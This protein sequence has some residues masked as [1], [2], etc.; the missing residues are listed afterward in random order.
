[1][2]RYIVR[3]GS[4][5]PIPLLLL[6]TGL[7]LLPLVVAPTSS[8]AATP[9][10][11]V[12]RQDARSGFRSIQAAAD[13]AL[14]GDTVLIYNGTYRE[15]VTVP[16]KRTTASTPITFAAAPGQHPIISGSEVEEGWQN[17]GGGVWRLVMNDSYFGSFNPFA[18]TWPYS[19]LPNS[20]VPRTCGGVFLGQTMLREKATLNGV[21]DTPDTWTSEVTDLTTTIW[22]NFGDNNPNDGDAEITKRQTDFEGSWNASY[23]HVEGLEFSRATSPQTV[24][25]WRPAAVSAGGALNTEGGYRWVI[26]DDTFTQNS[27]VAL[28]FGLGSEGVIERHGGLQPAR[29]G[30]DQIEDNLFVDNGS[31]GAFA[32]KAPFTTIRDNRFVDDN[33]FELDLGSEA[34]L[35]IVDESP[36]LMIAHNYFFNDGSYFTPAIWLDSEVQDSAV[37]G[38]VFVNTGGVIYE[39]DLVDNLFDNNILLNTFVPADSSLGDPD[40]GIELLESSGVYIVD[41]LF[42]DVARVEISNTHVE[43]VPGSVENDD[44]VAR[45]MALYEPGTLRSLGLYRVRVHQN[46][47][48]NNVFYDRGITSVQFDQ[49]PEY[50]EAALESGDL[51]QYLANK[52]WGNRVNFNLYFDGAQEVNDF[53]TPAPPNVDAPDSHSIVVTGD[54]STSYACSPDQCVVNM[55]VD[56][57]NSPEAMHAPPIT[58]SY[59]GRCELLPLDRAPEV[60]TDFFGKARF[61]SH[62]AVGP[63]RSTHAGDQVLRVWP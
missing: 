18:T 17:G 33:T 35:K 38:N 34:Y 31:D 9:K 30:Y 41:N 29:F 50:N 57:S 3:N 7:L 12:V 62:I 54:E 23:I 32:W 26:R 39:A 45:R 14:P 16:P 46:L 21:Q 27:G 47:I 56:P 20:T 61:P 43:D 22:A 59:L 55:D 53:D 63:F 2:P 37:S 44:G 28:D 5:C 52:F 10:I 4:L 60:S 49:P 24:N 42:D 36:G 6:T 51:A 1:V 58:G 15:S 48:S 11:L 40:G 25:Y 8:G 19:T 13:A